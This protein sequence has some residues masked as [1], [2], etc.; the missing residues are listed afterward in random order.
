MLQSHKRF[1]KLV[2]DT[3]NVE[4]LYNYFEHSVVPVDISDLLR[5]QWVQCISAF[6][7]FVHDVVR[8]GMVE[9]FLENRTPTP[10]YNTFQ[11]DI[12]TYGDMINNIIDASLIFER[13]IIL[14]HGFLAFQDPSK[15]ADALSYIWNENDKWGKI[16]NLM[17]MSKDDCTTYLRNIVIRRNQIV[18]EGDYTDSL[19]RRQD[20]FLQDVIDIRDYILKLGQAI[21]DCVS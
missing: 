18:H 10:K 6:D 15:V 3:Q 4:T 17:G 9:I 20:I 21:Y 7:K 12:Q 13:K 5:W 2:Q 16:S 8:V 14:K 11:I 1:V 19:S